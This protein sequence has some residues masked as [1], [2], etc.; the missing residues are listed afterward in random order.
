MDDE[1]QLLWIRKHIFLGALSAGIGHVASSLSLAE[2]VYVLYQKGILRHHPEDP[3]WAGRD[4]L[5]L[6]KGHGSLAL[7][8]VLAQA[9][10]F[11]AEELFQFGRIGSRLGGEPVWPSTPGVEAST[12]SLGHGLSVGFGMAL[13]LKKDK[14]D[15]RVF[16]ILGDG[17]CQEG[18]VWE[19]LYMAPRF[20]LD[21]L[22][23]IIDDNGIQKMDRTSAVAGPDNLAERLRAFQ[24]DVHEV[25]GHDVDALTTCFSNL[26]PNGRP[27]AVVAHTVKGH[28]LSCMQDNPAWHYRMPGKRDLKTVIREL[29]ITEEELSACK[30]RL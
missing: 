7:Y 3:N 6:S 9:G 14:A 25:D 12:G 28:G 18:S 21:N 13:A 15:N 10:Y 22:I 30:E 19:A 8:S 1:K 27:M 29:G 20:G 2:I 17:E 5:L 26:A 24:W 16:V 11:Q 4:R 23:A